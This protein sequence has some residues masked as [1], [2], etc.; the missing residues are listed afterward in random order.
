MA[1][2]AISL[3]R[4]ILNVQYELSSIALGKTGYAGHQ[5]RDYQQLDDFIVPMNHACN[6]HG[7][8]VLFDWTEKEHIDCHLINADDEAQERV[9]HIPVR[10]NPNGGRNM[11]P[12]QEEGSILTYARRYLLT[13]I[14]HIS[15][16][17]SMEDNTGNP[18]IYNNPTYRDEP[19]NVPT[20]PVHPT[21]TVQEAPKRA[22]MTLDELK[23][24]DDKSSAFCFNQTK[25]VLLALYGYD[26]AL[27]TTDPKNLDVMKRANDDVVNAFGCP[28]KDVTPDKWSDFYEFV[29][30]ISEVAGPE[31]FKDDD[32][33]A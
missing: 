4:R 31:T 24:I 11:Q 9:V 10:E 3:A 14:F 19:R 20:E 30:G 13:A 22:Y 33:N 12:M 21:E 25:R 6:K 2:E 5:N 7:L 23:A 15:A 18:A 26:F 28:A 29:V 16:H 1:N 17:D 32:I 8:L 27:S